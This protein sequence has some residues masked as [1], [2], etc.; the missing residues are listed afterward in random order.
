MSASADILS[1]LVASPA[2]L[3][4]ADYLAHPAA[5]ASAP[6]GILDGAPLRFLIAAATLCVIAAGMFTTWLHRDRRRFG[7]AA[8]AM[9]RAAGVPPLQWRLLQRLARFSS[10][11]NTGCLLLSEGCFD[12]AAEAYRRRF[13]ANRRLVLLRARLFE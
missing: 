2:G 1:G 9:A 10:F 12:V 7:S 13:G 4:P 8:R 6:P 5:R 3:A 11:P